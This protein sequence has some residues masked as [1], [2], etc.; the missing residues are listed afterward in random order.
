M[1]IWNSYLMLELKVCPGHTATGTAE[2]QQ[3]KQ[4]CWNHVLT[5][6]GAWNAT[7]IRK[8]CEV[9][10]WGIKDSMSSAVAIWL[11]CCFKIIYLLGLHDNSHANHLIPQCVHNKYISSTP[12]HSMSTPE[13]SMTTFF[14][15]DLHLLECFHI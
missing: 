12:D 8:C 11:M 7:R 10:E 5:M 15:A 3:I 1:V 9:W 14:S 4:E 6:A 13:G 2:H